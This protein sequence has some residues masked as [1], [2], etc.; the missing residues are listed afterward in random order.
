VAH[1]LDGWLTDRLPPVGSERTVEA[2]G[3]ERLTARL[4]ALRHVDCALEPEAHIV[5]RR[6]RGND[7]CARLLDRRKDVGHEHATMNEPEQP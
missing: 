2:G 4:L 3:R 1:A 7:L 6:R 5:R